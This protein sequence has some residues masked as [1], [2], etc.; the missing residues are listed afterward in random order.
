MVKLHFLLQRTFFLKFKTL[1]FDLNIQ[2]SN[3]YAME[4]DKMDFI[5]VLL[6]FL[7][8]NAICLLR[9]GLKIKAIAR[10]KCR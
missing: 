7:F 8:P 6:I 2:I 1:I 4:T 9:E 5:L 3:V 10:K